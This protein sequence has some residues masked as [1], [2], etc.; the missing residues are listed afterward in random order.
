MCTETSTFLDEAGRDLT[1]ATW[2]MPNGEMVLVC[3]GRDG[4]HLYTPPEWNNARV[5][6]YA[7]DS[8]GR[9]RLHGRYLEPDNPAWV[10]PAAVRTGA[11]SVF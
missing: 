1:P 8:G 6:S 11:R 2:K 4:F 5:P 3:P 7:A 9:V 10:V